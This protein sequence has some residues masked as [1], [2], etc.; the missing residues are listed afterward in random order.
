MSTVMEKFVSRFKQDGV[1]HVRVGVSAET[2]IGRL[3]APE[4]RKRF[5]IPRVGDFLTPVCFVNWLSTGDEE[6]RH[7]PKYRVKDTVR[8]YHR[9]IMYAKFYQLCSM[10]NTL[11][12]E[13]RSLPFVSYKIHQSG[14]K[15]FDRWKEYPGVVK[16]MIEHVLDPARG[17]KVPFAWEDSVEAEVSAMIDAIVAASAP[18]EVVEAVEAIAPVEAVAPDI[19]TEEEPVEDHKSAEETAKA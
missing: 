7:D 1:D 2:T 10:R 6:A 18:D 13:M 14:I 16:E 11:A 19:V 8:G 5:Y 15:E 9:F 17:G 3:A 12:K 4:W